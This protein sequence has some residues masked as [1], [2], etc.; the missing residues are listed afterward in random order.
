LQK[1][2][3]EINK[4]KELS[5]YLMEQLLILFEKIKEVQTETNPTGSPKNIPTQETLNSIVFDAQKESMD[6]AE[7]RLTD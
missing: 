6:R 5:N 2:Q 1:H 3:E 7:H 4:V